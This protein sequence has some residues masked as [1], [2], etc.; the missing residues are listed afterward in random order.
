MFIKLALSAAVICFCTMTGRMFAG[1]NSRRAR[2]LAELMDAIQLLRVH[3][4]DRLLPMKAALERSQSF[5]L[6]ETGAAMDGTSAAAAWQIVKERQLRRGG[7]LDCLSARDIDVLD[8]LFES[9]GTTG[10][11]EQR[12]IIDGTIK[13]L[14]LLEAAAKAECN[15]KG[16]LYTTL[17]A[18][19][20]VALVIGLI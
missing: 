17:G 16:R 19:A 6:N 4:L 2:M 8:K 15:E 1:R 5:A 18:L 7:K 9:L 20:G 10:I 11:S 12:P 3:M 13:E 14:G